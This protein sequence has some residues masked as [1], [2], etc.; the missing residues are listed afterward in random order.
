MRY[1]T[2][3]FQSDGGTI[4]S[5]GLSCEQ[6]PNFQKV[7]ARLLETDKTIQGN[8]VTITNVIELNED[9]FNSWNGIGGEN[10]N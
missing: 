7:T 4:G 8:A 6:Y 3:F 2:I 10:D 5:K 1:F 9:D